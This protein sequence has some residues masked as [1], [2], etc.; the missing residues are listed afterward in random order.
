MKVLSVSL[1]PNKLLPQS[2]RKN[3]LPPL[4]NATL[5]VNEHWNAYNY[6][7]AMMQWVI[8]TLGHKHYQRTYTL[9]KF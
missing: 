9:A 6:Y 8:S 5:I 4:G 1:N 3:P 7:I 2:Q